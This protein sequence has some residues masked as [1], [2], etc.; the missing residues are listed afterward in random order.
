[1][2]RR[3]S[4]HESTAQKLRLLIALQQSFS[5][6]RSLPQRAASPPHAIAHRAAQCTPTAKRRRKATNFNP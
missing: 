6:E 4:K 3:F 5:P 1:M 2:N